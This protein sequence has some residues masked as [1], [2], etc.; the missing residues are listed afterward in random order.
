MARVRRTARTRKPARRRTAPPARRGEGT[1]SRGTRT[2]PGWLR[3]LGSRLASLAS[4]PLLSAI[5]VAVLGLGGVASLAPTFLAKPLPAF[6]RW[7]AES[8]LLPAW[9]WQVSGH[10][11]VTRAM[12][13]EALAPQADKPLIFININSLKETLE[14]NSWIEKARVTRQW[15]DSLRIELTERTPFALWQSDGRIQVIDRKGV[16]IQDASPE[17][18]DD[19]FLLV[20]DGANTEA[21]TL[22]AMLGEQPEI[23]KQVMAAIR[24]GNRRWDLLMAT[25]VSVRLPE[26][27]AFAALDRLAEMQ[28]SERIL[29]RD[30]GIIDLRLDDRLIIAPN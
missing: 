13:A 9:S 26:R 4:R 5:I 7:V 18:F 29:D 1:T 6:E 14:N 8:A 24:V 17:A 20:G 11:H 19:L 12:I 27:K 21:G 23:A 3:N 2:N 22:I 16:V 15:P 30:V 10:H 28:R 25:G